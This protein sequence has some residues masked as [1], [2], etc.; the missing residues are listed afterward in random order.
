MVTTQSEMK[1]AD[2]TMAIYATTFLCR[3]SRKR[4]RFSGKANWASIHQDSA[5]QVFSK[6]SRG[7]CTTFHIRKISYEITNNCLLRYMIKGQIF[8][9]K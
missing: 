7:L 3:N 8:Y 1:K 4:D 6:I 2:L 9:T 5:T